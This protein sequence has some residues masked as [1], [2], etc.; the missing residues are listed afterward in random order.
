MY[1][2]YSDIGVIILAVVMIITKMAEY[3]MLYRQ[4]KCATFL[5]RIPFFR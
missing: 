3:L 2:M 5:I 4:L 1:V